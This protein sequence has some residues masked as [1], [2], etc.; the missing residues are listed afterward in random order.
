MA[1]VLSCMYIFEIFLKQIPEMIQKRAPSILK[2][3]PE[4]IQKRV[5][6]LSCN[7][8]E[9]NKA[10]PY[11]ERALDNSGF[12]INLNYTPENGKRRNR[13]RN[14]TW[15]NP[16]FSSSVET[17]VGKIFLNLVI[18]HFPPA[19]KYHRIFNR[20]NLKLSYS[21]MPNMA[22]II[23]SH[24]KAILNET[25]A[26]P[27]ATKSCNCRNR[28][29]CPLEGNCL[30]KCLVYKAVV[31]TEKSTKSYIGCCETAFKTR[32]SN[33]KLSF[34]KKTYSTRTALSKHIWNLKEN[35][36]EFKISWSVI[37][38][39]SPN[40]CKGKRCNLCLT[41]KLL[42]NKCMNEDLLNTRDELLSKCRHKNKY[43]LKQCN[44]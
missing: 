14:V 21:C 7:K 39:V 8:A 5:S 43:K 18:K 42:I 36:S 9:F 16:P 26:K 27:S 35:N 13:R 38:Q 44:L 23:K 40:F 37:A 31:K 25:L 41:E 24:N 22:A 29:Q 33:H 2:Q 11:Y 12:K 4:M 6:S 10:K 1:L 20:R 34:S 15:F 30:E 17:N 32:Y 3:I 28:D 19:H